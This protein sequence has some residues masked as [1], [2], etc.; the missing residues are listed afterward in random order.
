MKLRSCYLSVVGHDDQLHVLGR[1]LDVAFML[2]VSGQKKER[3]QER[4]GTASRKR[5][6]R[7]EDGR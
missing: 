3:M 6:R 5:E 1:S 7:E 4:E 2:E